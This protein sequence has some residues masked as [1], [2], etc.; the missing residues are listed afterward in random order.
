MTTFSVLLMIPMCV[1][2]SSFCV[3]V[4]LCIFS[5]SVKASE[6]QPINSTQRIFT[7]STRLLTNKRTAGDN[8]IYRIFGW[9]FKY[10]NKNQDSFRILKK[11]FSE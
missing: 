9:L 1:T 8:G 4:R 5:V 7:P 11:Q 3:N 2:L 10:K 6:L